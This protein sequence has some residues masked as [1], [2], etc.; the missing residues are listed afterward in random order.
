MVEIKPGLIGDS[1][2]TGKTMMT[3]VLAPF[4]SVMKQTSFTIDI[5]SKLLQ[6]FKDQNGAAFSLLD[7][8][9]KNNVGV[10]TDLLIGEKGQDLVERNLEMATL[11]GA[12]VPAHRMQIVELFPWLK[13]VKSSVSTRIMGIL[14]EVY[15]LSLVMMM[16]FL[17]GTETLGIFSC[18]I[19]AVIAHYPAIQERINSKIDDVIGDRQVETDDMGK[20]PY[21]MATILEVLR[22]CIL[23]VAKS[24]HLTLE[25]TTLRG[26]DLPAGTRV[27]V[28]TCAAH[29]DPD[30][31]EDPY[32]YKPERFL[33]S[34]GQ[35]L[36]AD[37]PIRRQQG[38]HRDLEMKFHDFFMTFH[39]HFEEFHDFVN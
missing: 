14:N 2:H 18:L 15:T 20:C 9:Y 5:T 10:M 36:P 35:F 29:H 21:I 31:W 32:V 1:E 23:A 12:A 7:A 3:K 24:P 25:D 8:M 38:S 30:V 16:V 26:Y 39:D 28:H 27:L 22:N 37:H 33:D 34:D 19:L 17:G 4:V 11:V 6:H 13:Y